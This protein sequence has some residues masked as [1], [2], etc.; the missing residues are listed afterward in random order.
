MLTTHSYTYDVLNRLLKETHVDPSASNEEYA[1]DG[2]ALTTG[3]GQLPPAITSTYPIG[4]RTAMCEQ[5]S[6][7][8]WS[9]DKMGRPLLESTRNL[10]SAQKVLNVNYTYYKD[11]SLNTL[12]YPS[13]DVVTY[14]VL[15]A[16]RATQ[17]TDSANNFVIGAT[18]AAPGLLTSMTNGS[19]IVTSNSYNDRL[20]PVLL[21]AG[22]TGQNPIFSLCYDFH[23]HMAINNSSCSFTAYTATGDNGNVF[24]VLNNVDSTRNAVYA[25]DAL[26][27]IAQA[28][29]I[30][31]TGPNCWGEAYTI[32]PWG[33]LTN[34]AGVSGM[35]GCLTEG[36]STTPTTKNQLSGIGLQYDAAGNVTTDNLGN[37]LTYD[38]EN[39]IATVTGFT[40][41]YDADGTR[42]EKSAG[43]S[44]TMYWLGTSGETLA[45]TDLTGTINEEYIYFN[46]QRIAR[47]DRPSGAVHYYFSNHLGSHTVVTNAVGGCEQDIEYYPYGGV[48]ADH[49]PTVA[50]HYKFTGKER[51]S[52]SNLDNF[53]ARYYGSSLGRFITPDDGSDQHPS[54][55]ESW[56]LYSYVRNNPLSDTDPTGRCMY[57]NGKYTPDDVS[58]CSE[59]EDKTQPPTITVT[60]KPPST[61]ETWAD[62]TTWFANYAL[63]QTVGNWL[64]SL[65]TANR[66]RDPLVF[67][68][69]VIGLINIFGEGGEAENTIKAVV[70]SAEGR[71]QRTDLGRRACTGQETRP[72]SG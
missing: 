58:N 2:V 12:T 50:Q 69:A 7:S 64:G 66:T 59:V 11:G 40:Y 9:F 19:G 21:S 33:N 56:N 1:Y 46:G 45:E 31:T 18:Y 17:V 3:C 16:G 41:Y 57:S 61:F 52:E 29:T 38:A 62:N 71:T 20:Q 54:D 72:R 49:C 68:V 51:D 10:G 30:A 53:G 47:V 36:L 27:R 67:G 48:I 23:L 35:G 63:D 37:V 70:E 43:S 65:M 4:R 28:N 13:G 42:M 8:S 15:G 22:L 32:D 55:P 44:G 14:K 5:R 34:R 60:A 26:N 25:Y 6:G 39:R 24:Q